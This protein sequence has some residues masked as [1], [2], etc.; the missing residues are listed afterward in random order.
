[1]ISSYYKQFV[2]ILLISCIL[3]TIGQ[4]ETYEH[5][6]LPLVSELE[7]SFPNIK[8][9]RFV[10]VCEKSGLVLHEKKFFEAVNYDNQGNQFSLLD[11]VKPARDRIIKFPD[12]SLTAV[13]SYTNKY[14]CQ[15]KIVLSETV[16]TI[17]SYES[18]KKKI[19]N[20]LDQFFE[21]KVYKKG[22]YIANIPV[23]YAK[24]INNIDIFCNNDIYVP[25]S[26]KQYNKITK[27]VIYKV[28]ITAPVSVNSKLG[29]IYIY[30]PAFQNPIQV[31]LIAEKSVPRGSRL[32]TMIDSI[33]YII[34]GP[35]YFNIN[36]AY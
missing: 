23:A 11:I 12:G 3:G 29:D 36:T 18:D 27:R 32:K 6:Q 34:F 31:N 25:L 5:H 35:N 9:P 2:R 17:P 1:M 22:E 30:I 10:I 13:F 15:F 14:K 8:A 19:M 16:Q 33:K 7:K 4:G 28:I 24:A 26:D 20:W 21:F